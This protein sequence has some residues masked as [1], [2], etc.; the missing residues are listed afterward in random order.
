[1]SAAIAARAGSVDIGS[2]QQLFSWVGPT[3]YDVSHDGQRFLLLDPP[4]VNGDSTG[5]NL[6]VLSNWQNALKK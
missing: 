2:P 1:M 5:G 4:G 3:S 6:I